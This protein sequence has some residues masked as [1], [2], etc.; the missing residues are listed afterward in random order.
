VLKFAH[1]IRSREFIEELLIFAELV[2]LVEDNKNTPPSS[3][4][5]V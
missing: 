2:D 3:S 1:R 4:S 5:A